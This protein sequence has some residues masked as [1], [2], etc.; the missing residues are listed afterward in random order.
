MVLLRCNPPTYQ[1]AWPRG[2]YAAC[3]EASPP[4]HCLALLQPTFKW[5]RVAVLTFQAAASI[6]G[7]RRAASHPAPS[8]AEPARRMVQP[9]TCRHAFQVALVSDLLSPAPYSC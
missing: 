1:A 5:E 2:R 4:H 7:A 9:A 8:S 6:S 3:G